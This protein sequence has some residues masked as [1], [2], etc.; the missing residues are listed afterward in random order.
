MNYN[1]K[2]FISNIITFIVLLLSLMVINSYLQELNYES[3][4]RYYNKYGNEK[5]NINYSDIEIINN[6]NINQYP[7]EEFKIEYD[8]IIPVAVSLILI[9]NTFYYIIQKI[10]IEH[11]K[12]KQ[13]F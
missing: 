9:L 12:R 2:I 8:L 1:K 10:Y 13:H 4:F 5:I 6:S 3:Q 7:T 11:N